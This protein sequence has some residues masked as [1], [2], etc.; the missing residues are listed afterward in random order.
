MKMTDAHKDLKKQIN[1]Y[2]RSRIWL[3][4]SGNQFA[5][6]VKYLFLYIIKNR[7]DIFA[8]YI[9]ESKKIADYITDLGY[10]AITFNSPI[11]DKVLPKVGFYVVE[12]VK[13]NFPDALLNAKLINLFHGVGLKAIERCWS[14]DFLG[15][16]IAKKYIRYN[17][18]YHTHMCFL[19]TS[20]FMEKHFKQQLDLRDDQIIRAGY[21]RCTKVLERTYDPKRVLDGMEGKTVALY[22]PTYREHDSRN[23]LYKAIRNIYALIETLKQCNI[24][25]IIKL[26][27]KITNDFYFDKF[28]KIAD[29]CDNL[30]LWDNTYDV[31]EIFEYVKIGIIDY[32]SMYYDLLA[33]GVTKFIR[34]IFDYNDEN[35]FLLYDYF[36][37]THGLICDNFD[38]FLESLKTVSSE[39]VKQENHQNIYNKFWSYTTNDPCANIIEQAYAFQVKEAPQSTLY[40]FDIFDT[41][42][43]RH[44]LKPCGIFY[45]VQEKIATSNEGFPE[46]FKIRYAEIRIDAEASVREYVK[47]SQGDFEI[48]FD[49]IFDRLKDVYELK[50]LQVELLKKWEIELELSNVIPIKKNIEYAESLLLENETV[51]LISDMYL[52]EDIIR[53][54][55]GIVSQTLA[56]AKIFLSSTQRVQKTTQKLYLAVYRALAP[57]RYTEWH[58]YGDNTF[59]DSTVAGNFGITPHIH[60]IPAFN[61]FE[62]GLV[63]FCRHYDAYLVAG[64]LARS[65]FM[66]SLSHKEYY[67]YAHLGFCFIPYIAWVI[68][69]ALR[70]KTKTLYFISRDGYFLKIIADSYLTKLNLT[71]QIRTKYIYGSRK[72]W[73]LPAMIEEVDE[74]FF[75]NFGNFVGVDCY[76]K[77]LKSININHSTF[78]K[79]FPELNLGFSSSITKHDVKSIVRYFQYS[80]K[81]KN[82][83]LQKAAEKRQI[84]LDYLRQEIDF[85]EDFAFVEF[86]G[87][88][89]TQTLFGRLLNLAAEKQT[90]NIYYYFRS[91]LPSEGDNIRYNFT[92]NK[93]SLIFVES[94]FANFPKQTVRAYEKKKDRIVPVMDDEPYDAELFYAIQ[95]HTV[96]FLN[97]LFSLPFLADKDTILRL[98]ADYELFWFKNNQS[99]PVLIDALAHL[100]DSVELWGDVREFAPEFTLAHLSLLESGK[101]VSSFTRSL[102]MSLARAS[103]SAKEAYEEFLQNRTMN[104][105]S[106]EGVALTRKDRLLIK[107]QKDPKRFF[108]DS[109]NPLFRILGATL[110]SKPFRNNLGKAFVSYVQKHL[111]K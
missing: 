100:R 93:T 5:G 48:T 98:L 70:N 62:E 3:F 102:P 69:H 86:W 107:L 22:V 101:P 13:E 55:L 39:Q 111:S 109:K 92:T 24:L 74:E 9:S 79:L 38:Q 78:Q 106:E 47:K 43:S 57:F 36:S 23:F 65:R 35:K 81:F 28:S 15:M 41:L 60:E 87:R 33:A 20:P 95:N 89:Y 66:H 26:H 2:P 40:S 51:V 29:N 8:C 82:Y 45:G 32:S 30:I 6:N 50:A 14:R 105:V 56:N 21:P 34:Y 108:A 97:E 90:K 64:L 16:Q 85:S 59:A 54:M 25:L 17:H 83:L 37:N 84:V 11:A 80:E 31:Y 12:Q 91:I 4:N 104:L 75:S 18:F 96:A 88:G 49:G 72:V 71:D 110:L 42:I 61:D 63:T 1:S 58:H 44:V 76:S 94:V 67:A 46:I 27:P 52:P 77:L 10:N 73:R 53:K 19:A 7:K 103:E 68:T 99:D